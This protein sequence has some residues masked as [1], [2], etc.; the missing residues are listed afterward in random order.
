MDASTSIASMSG[1][2]AEGF[3]FGFNQF[4]CFV[5]RLLRVAHIG[6]HYRLSPSVGAPHVQ[7]SEGSRILLGF[8]GLYR[9]GSLA[10]LVGYDASS[11]SPVYRCQR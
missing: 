7:M 1:A 5:L 10:D 6:H 9:L 2:P 4:S 11:S 8:R 3:R